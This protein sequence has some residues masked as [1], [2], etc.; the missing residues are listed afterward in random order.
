MNNLKFNPFFPS[1]SFQKTP[2]LLRRGGSRSLTGR[3]REQN[4]LNK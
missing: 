4:G 1:R 3:S 2:I